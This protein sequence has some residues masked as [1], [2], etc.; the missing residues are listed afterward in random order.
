MFFFAKLFEKGYPIL[1]TSPIIKTK[2]V[3]TAAVNVG[4]WLPNDGH[5]KL[6]DLHVPAYLLLNIFKAKYL[7]S[8]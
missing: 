2:F 6:Y 4:C 8:M 5:L 7:T 1:S 3:Q